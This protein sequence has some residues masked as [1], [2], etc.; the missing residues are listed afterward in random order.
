MERDI[1]ERIDNF[2]ESVEELVSM[3]FWFLVVAGLFGFMVVQMWRAI[4]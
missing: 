1:F 2:M 3:L 4:S